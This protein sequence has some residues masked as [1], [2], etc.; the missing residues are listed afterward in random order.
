MVFGSIVEMGRICG[1]VNRG[2][3][4]TREVRR[5]KS[6]KNAKSNQQSNF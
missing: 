3:R 2:M 4:A 6:S 1:I 5:L